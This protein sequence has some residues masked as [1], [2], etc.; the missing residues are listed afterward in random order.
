[1]SPHDPDYPVLEGVGGRT[2]ENEYLLLSW[3][4]WE[5]ALSAIVKLFPIKYLSRTLTVFL[6]DKGLHV[7]GFS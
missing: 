7:Q 5:A 1:V 6:Q 2:K 4:A 3:V